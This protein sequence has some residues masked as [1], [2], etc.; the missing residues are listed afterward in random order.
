M[1]SA[2]GLGFPLYP[3]SSARKDDVER[4]PALHRPSALETH[5]IF[6]QVYGQSECGPM[7]LRYHRLENLETVSGRDMGIGLEGYTEARITDA[8]G[9]PLPAG[10]NGHI[11]FL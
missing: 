7:I 3:L 9:N 2:I 5:P 8:Q 4:A 1:S 6:M 10:E 11:Q